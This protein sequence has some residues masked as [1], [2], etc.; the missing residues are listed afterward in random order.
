MTAVFLVHLI[1]VLFHE[2]PR[3]FMDLCRVGTDM[4]LVL[5]GCLVYLSLRFRP[6]PFD[7]FLARR[8]ARIYPVFAF[9]LIFYIAAAVALPEMSRLPAGRGAAAWMILKNAALVPLAFGAPRII[10]VSWTLGYIC[11]F[12]VVIHPLAAWTSGWSLR[13]RTVLWSL[14][15]VLVYLKAGRPALLPAGVLLA[16]W[17]P[18]AKVPGWILLPAAGAAARAFWGTEHLGTILGGIG[19]LALCCWL[20]PRPTPRPMLFLSRISYSF[21]LTHGLALL[22]VAHF[23][24]PRWAAVPAAG[25]SALAGAYIMFRFVEQ[26][27]SPFRETSGVT[28]AGRKQAHSRNEYP[29]PAK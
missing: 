4:F 11:L 14:L 20:L 29:I 6:V 25:I 27:F 15:S 8:L 12:Y 28:T 9:V 10:T 21:Y 23:A 24:A 13:R 18:A 1:A 22:T 16:E 7:V 3:P 5:T 2:Q 17:M 26:P 19:A